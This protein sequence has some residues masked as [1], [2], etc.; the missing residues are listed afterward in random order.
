MTTKILDAKILDIIQFYRKLAGV[1]PWTSGFCGNPRGR[2][3]LPASNSVE[4]IKSLG[5]ALSRDG[6][7]NTNS[8][9]QSKH[10]QEK[11]G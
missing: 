1:S 5:N 2:Y 9:E 3:Y 11:G 6:R 10:Y 4:I 7:G 8:Y